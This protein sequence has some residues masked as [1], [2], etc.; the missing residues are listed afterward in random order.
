MS[1]TPSA[2]S[3]P[4][5]KNQPAPLDLVKAVGKLFDIAA[6][7][8]TPLK[9]QVMTRDK[10]FEM[11]VLARLLRA[12]RRA[13][14]KAS[15]VHVPPSK[16]GKASELVVASKPALA[17]RKR[18][19]HFDLFDDAGNPMGEVWTSVEFESLS[20]DRNG[21]APGKAPREARHEL[22][23]CVLAPAADER[24]A[25]SQVIAGISCKDV[26]TS[27]KENVREALGL[28]RETAFLRDPQPSLATWLVPVV[29]AEPSAPILLVSSDLGV[30]KYSSPVDA[31][32][33]Y[34]RFVRR[35]WESEA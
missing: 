19:S 33:V 20:W 30:K 23:V 35:P 16:G 21:G 17:D 3:V 8:P 24:P 15:I 13:Y 29:P 27:T 22:D 28:R 34:V 32:G 2:A 9:L 11:L 26:R 5:K 1:T 7:A 12:F 4:K 14:P 25:H 18:F 10:L 31:L 6:K